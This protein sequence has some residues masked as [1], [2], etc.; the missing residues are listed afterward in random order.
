MSVKAA[1]PPNALEVPIFQGDLL[2]SLISTVERAEGA[3]PRPGSERLV[4]HDAQGRDYVRFTR[5][6]ADLDLHCSN[7]DCQRKAVLL[8]D[9]RD[10][11]VL[12]FCLAC[13]Y[14]EFAQWMVG[15]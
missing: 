2:D 8:R 9:A 14:V 15:V 6:P 11:D 4:L 13:A 7:V 5:L 12:R 10:E 1:L 3:S